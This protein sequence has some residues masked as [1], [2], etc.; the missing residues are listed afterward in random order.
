MSGMSPRILIL[1]AGPAGLAAGHRLQELGHTDFT[2]YE[3]NGHV[4]GE[5][6]SF[7][8]PAGFCWDL[9]GHVMFSKY[10]Y[11]HELHESLLGDEVTTLRREA[12]IRMCGRDVPYPF[13]N[14]L[15]H[16][17]P[18]MAADCLAGLAAA[19]QAGGTPR[20]FREWIEM[21]MGQ[22]IARHFMFPYNEKVWAHPLEDMS[23]SWIAE[24][25]SRVSFEEVQK[26]M[27]E[28]APQPWGP[29]S[30]FR[31]PR[32]GGFQEPFRRLG[33]RL[34]PHL[35]LNCAVQSVDCLAKTVML[36][37]GTRDRYDFLITTAPLD[38]FCRLTEHLPGAVSRRAQELKCSGVLAVGIGLNRR[39]TATKCW[40][41]FPEKEYIFNRL[42]YLSNYSPDITPDPENCAALL[43]EVTYS[44]HKPVDKT[45]VVR[46]VIGGL[47]AAGVLAEADR[48]H[49]VSTHVIDAEYGYPVPTLERDVI[50]EY[51]QAELERREIF[52]RGRFGAW[53]YEIGNSDHA[54]MMGKEI[55]DRLLTGAEETVFHG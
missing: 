41:Y 46:D 19:E 39:L 45:S 6:A 3:Q 48:K 14:H 43:C 35:R 55:V 51:V 31:Y 32:S 53:K 34:S 50:L 25:V 22:G 2:L 5:S 23:A 8:D 28:D 47:V 9:G 40:V 15:K 4:G 16:L 13:Q 17:P 38:L 12:W 37:D 49:I 42:T 29:N 11:V 20:N 24:R 36:P 21:Q 27:R 26:H 52:S 44:E 30:V 33:L 1:G 10:D 54:I 18:Q 7:R